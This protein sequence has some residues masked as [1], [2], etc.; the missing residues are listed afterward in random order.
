MPQ[1]TIKD[2]IGDI[3][4]T[5]NPARL[6]ELFVALFAKGRR[7]VRDAR[8]SL[9]SEY[10]L[11]LW[12]SAGTSAAVRLLEVAL[13]AYDSDA[14]STE[15]RELLR[16][17]PAET[18]AARTVELVADRRFSE[19]SLL[20]DLVRHFPT[21]LGL[22]LV[23]NYIQAGHP[24][25]ALSLLESQALAE[26][27]RLSAQGLTLGATAAAQVSDFQAAA[28]FVGQNLNR[29]VFG[30]DEAAAVCLAV[31]NGAYREAEEA[32]GQHS[33]DARLAEPIRAAAVSLAHNDLRSAEEWISS[34]RSLI[35]PISD[36][37][38]RLTD[39]RHLPESTA[40][41][42]CGFSGEGLERCMVLT[43]LF[44]AWHG[45]EPSTVKVRLLLLNLLTT[46]GNAEDVPAVP[47]HL[48]E[49]VNGQVAFIDDGLLS[50]ALRV[51][52]QCELE[53]GARS[54]SA[55]CVP[56][57]G[58]AEL[59]FTLERGAAAAPSG[60]RVGVA[61]RIL[62][63][64]GAPASREVT[65]DDVILRVALP[66]DGCRVS[67]AGGG[68]LI[69]TVHRVTAEERRDTAE[70]LSFLV[71]DLKNGFSFIAQWAGEVEGG[72]HTLAALQERIRENVDKMAGYL[73]D[74][75]KYLTLESDET[76]QSFSLEEAVREVA[77]LLGGACAS[78]GTGLVVEAEP[79]LPSYRGQRDRILSIL[80][81]LAKNSLE[82]METGGELR[83][84]ARRGPSGTLVLEVVDTGPGLTGEARQRLF[85]LS[86]KPAR[87]TGRGIGLWAV[88][89]HLEREG[90]QL[91][92]V[93][94]EAGTRFRVS[95]PAQLGPATAESEPDPN[96]LAPE[97]LKAWRAAGE[98]AATHSPPWETI[99][100]LIRRAVLAQVQ[101]QFGHLML[102][103]LYLAS[104]L[105]LLDT[106]PGAPR[107]GR[108]LPAL[109]QHIQGRFPWLGDTAAVE[110]LLR[111]V[112]R[113]VLDDTLARELEN[114]TSVAVWLLVFGRGYR[115][116]GV[117]VAPLACPPG[118]PE[119]GVAALAERLTELDA[120]PTVQNEDGYLEAHLRGARVLQSLTNTRG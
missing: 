84:V 115:V 68:E 19:A 113:A 54:I 108:V 40:E 74:C 60:W 91:E 117:Q 114:L 67:R 105:Q 102:R 30:P 69:E 13:K 120:L 14:G 50:Y 3:G 72:K 92:V 16:E 21:P 66:L 65:D 23:R 31:R 22:R 27:D 97:A 63:E 80:L 46:M 93:S 51:L 41:S 37:C 75:L 5:S 61:Q 45:P 82:A 59:R 24:Q 12:K 85:E 32:L 101:H 87:G 103:S 49:G 1:P 2:I 17:L 44:E 8:N 25:D 106:G 36:S 33:L 57:D 100:F 119:A 118:W 10:F 4:R 64:I 11:S 6:V 90:G 76:V 38:A 52:L 70:M 88:R 48:Q 96:L 28:R 89:R 15:L 20:A 43:R 78:R 104:G 29:G 53:A 18:L 86:S 73:N 39:P 110:D 81:N 99:H 58:R 77:R 42:I 116:A 26:D 55:G 107:R 98:L 62:G 71:H 34:F 109:Q 35:D 83:L 47:T 94:G 95:L 9:G 79:G 56:A 111:C 7:G 112:L